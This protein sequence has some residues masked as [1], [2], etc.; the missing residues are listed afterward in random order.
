MIRMKRKITVTAT[1]LCMLMSA[2]VCEAAAKQAPAP[3]AI[4]VAPA[5]EPRM[6]PRQKEI[7]RVVGSADGYITEELHQEFWSSMP[8]NGQESDEFKALLEELAKRVFGPSQE[9]AYETWKSAQL[10]LRAGRVIR[11]EG[12]DPAIKASFAVSSIPSYRRQIEQAAENTDRILN[13][14]AD[15]TPFDG[16]EGPIFINEDMIAASLAGIEGGIDRLRLLLNPTW[17]P[18]LRYYKHPEAHVSV[19]A[20]WPF[21]PSRSTVTLTT[22]M[23]SD[24]YKLE[25]TVSDSQS[26]LIAFA[27]YSQGIRLSQVDLSNPTVAVLKNIE[28]GLKGAGAK[29]L[30]VSLAEEWRG[31]VSARGSGS[32]VNGQE[33]AFI[34]LRSVYLPEHEGFLV[35]TAVS[36]NSLSDAQSLMAVLEERTQVLR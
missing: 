1:L 16:P 27:D 31:Y 17:E 21:T 24:F 32:I 9:F 15:G 30:S 14:A 4:S 33:Q 20:A 22:G 35:F 13:A 18:S 26:Q 7:M 25:Q 2:T 29:P 12:L 6:T 5:Q 34:A 11:S 3:P 10:S 23:I 19:L 8:F 28:A 36:L